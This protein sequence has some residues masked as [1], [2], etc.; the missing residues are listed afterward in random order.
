MVIGA[1]GSKLRAVAWWEG[2]V[3]PFWLPANLLRAEGVGGCFKKQLYQQCDMTSGKYLEAMKT[4][5]MQH[6]R[7]QAKFYSIALTT[8]IIELYLNHRVSRQHQLQ[9]IH[10]G[11]IIPPIPCLFLSQWLAV[12]YGVVV[13]SVSHE[14]QTQPSPSTIRQQQLIVDLFNLYAT[15][16]EICSRQPIK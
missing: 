3:L 11:H 5:L 10:Q 15:I 4:L 6:S 13:Q 1:K 2:K 14:S 16:P 8:W 12:L 9:G 7:I